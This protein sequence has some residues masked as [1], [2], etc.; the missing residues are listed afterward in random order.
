[1]TRDEAVSFLHGVFKRDE[2][3]AEAVLAIIESRK[4]LLL[5]KLTGSPEVKG[6]DDI[7]HL[8]ECRA[9]IG[10]NKIFSSIFET[11]LEEAK[12]QE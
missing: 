9:C 5:D 12:T 11:L 10:E 8:V 1:M 4:S 6:L 7:K 3:V 2:R